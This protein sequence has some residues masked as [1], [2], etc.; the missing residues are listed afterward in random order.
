MKGDEP[1]VLNAIDTAFLAKVQ[2]AFSAMADSMP[3]MLTDQQHDILVTR[4]WVSLRRIRMAREVAL[5]ALAF[6]EPE[7]TKPIQKK[8]SQ[9]T[10]E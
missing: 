3:Q 10:K 1:P 4:F 8:P 9:E 5:A 6:K 2:Q 7:P